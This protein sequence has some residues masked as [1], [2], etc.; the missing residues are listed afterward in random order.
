MKH[1]ARS[2]SEGKNRQEREDGDKHGKE[3]GSANRSA[4]GDDGVEYVASNRSIAE[5][6]REVMGRVFGH[7]HG[8]VF[9][10]ADADGDPRQAHDVRR[11]AKDLHEEEADEDGKREGN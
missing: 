9:Q 1:F 7:H 6:S 4:G 8:L 11:D 3:D 10:D 5:T 2:T